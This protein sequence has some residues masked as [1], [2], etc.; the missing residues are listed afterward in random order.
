[1][2][3]KITYGRRGR[4][5]L[6]YL[7][8]P[9]KAEEHTDPHVVAGYDDPAELQPDQDPETGRWLLGGLAA[10]LDAPQVAAGARGVRRYVWQCSLSLPPDEAART[11]EQWQAI[12]ERFVA[13]MG[14]AGD[15]DRAGCRWVAIRHGASVG[16]NDHIHLL[17]TLATEDGA[18]V[19]LR[20]DKRRAQQVAGQIEDEFGLIKRIR[21]D[22]A[23]PRTSTSRPEVDRARAAGGV[24]E[25]ETLRRQVRA[26]AAGAGSEAEWIGRLKAA[27]LLVAPR[28]SRDDP[29]RVV[30]YAVA[31]SPRSPGGKPTW[32][33][34]RT[35]DGDLSLPRMRQ[36]WP[37]DVLV[38]PEQWRAVTATGVPR[39]TATQRAAVWRQA[40]AALG[41]VT[42]RMAQVPA[43]SAEWTAI[44]R[45]SADVLALVAVA[46]EPGGFGPVSRA[47]NILARSAAPV[48]GT[49]AGVAAVV[50]DQLGQVSNALMVAGSARDGGE[51]ALLAAVVVA[52]ARL[53]VLLAELGAARQQAAA[54]GA[55]QAAAARLLPLVAQAGQAE[56]RAAAAVAGQPVP[57][58]APVP[59]Q[60]RPVR[61]GEDRGRG[62]EQP[63]R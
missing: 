40:S 9:G 35:L 15:D 16:G 39:L 21:R 36:R 57:A 52:A 4:G 33:A 17:V 42:A 30:G 61:G 3:P 41:E 48:R 20:Q 18:P 22:G 62:G 59:G 63:Q 1:V 56:V 37:Q 46:A 14:F 34:G 45:S 6:E 2:Y 54:A 51:A 11:D 28:A 5:L 32:F 27:G 13:G 58:P 49:R 26:A 23:T 38:D 47:A 43:G 12:A 8:G 44:A 31:T 55:A 19:W 25:R 10:R 60:R 50:A 29:S 7:F 24:T 53:A